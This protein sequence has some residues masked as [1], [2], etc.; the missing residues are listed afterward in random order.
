MKSLSLKKTP[1]ILAQGIRGARKGIKSTG[2]P[3]PVV[4]KT[5]KGAEMAQ[6][7]MHL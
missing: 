5:L 2:R 1:L 7:S 6:Q 4:N 3:L